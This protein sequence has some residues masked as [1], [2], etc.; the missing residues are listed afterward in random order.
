VV[1]CA[2]L[3]VRPRPIFGRYQTAGVIGSLTLI[4]LGLALR[5]WAGGCAGEHTRNSTIEAPRLVTGGPFS[6]V[7]NPIYLASVILGFG[8]VALVGDPWLLGLY[9][10]VFVFLY[11]FIVPAEEKF[12]RERFGEAYERYCARV[13]RALPRWSAWKEAQP[14]PFD[15][16]ALLGEARLGLVLVAIYALLR[17][18]AWFRA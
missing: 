15:R 12:L 2:A 18:A 10:G 6:F 7:R 8:M 9:F 11:G 4:V 5:A 17:A 1:A 13:P 16:R 3:F 14:Q